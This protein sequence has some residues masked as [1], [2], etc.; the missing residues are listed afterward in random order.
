M[1]GTRSRVDSQVIDPDT[2]TIE[3][4]R[5]LAAP[6]DVRGAGRTGCRI[7]A[8]REALPLSAPSWVQRPT[9]QGSRSSS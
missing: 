6:A 3:A 7:R 1:A 5:A 8:L 4:R 2:M 9:R